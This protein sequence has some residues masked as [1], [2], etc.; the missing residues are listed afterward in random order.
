[1][2]VC[3]KGG[4][5]SS[6]EGEDAEVAEALAVGRDLDARD[7]EELGAEVEGLDGRPVIADDVVL[8]GHGEVD[9][10]RGEGEH[11]ILGRDGRVEARARVHVQVAPEDAG[12]RDDVSRREL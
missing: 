12:R 4:T 7:G 2:L 10:G 5:G 9:P 6:A 1:M 8:G 3:L 11:A